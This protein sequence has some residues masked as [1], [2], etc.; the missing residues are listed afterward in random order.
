MLIAALCFFCSRRRTIEQARLELA[1]RSNANW[2]DP[3]L[4]GV[5][6]QVGRS[7]GWRKLASLA[8]VAV[9][10]AGLAKEWFGRG[11]AASEADEADRGRLAGHPPQPGKGV[12]RCSSASRARLASSSIRPIKS[13]DAR[14]LELGPDPVDEGDIDDLAVE[15][16]GKIKQEGLEQH[17]ADIEHRPPSKTCDAVEAPVADAHAHRIDAVREAAGGIERA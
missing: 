4:I 11:G 15:V 17:R 8:A 2:L 14:K 7:I 13:C 16:A 12:G 3:R 5:G 6:V 1:A 10:A 9:L